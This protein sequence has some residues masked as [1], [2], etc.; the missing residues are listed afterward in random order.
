MVSRW[1]RVMKIEW[2]N[3]GV[4]PGCCQ[5]GGEREFIVHIRRRCHDW[6]RIMVFALCG[7][8]VAPAI[9]W[10]AQIIE[11][12]DFSTP[13]VLISKEGVTTFIF[14][15]SITKVIKSIP[16]M[17]TNTEGAYLFVS[18]GSQDGELIVI[19]T[20]GVLYT[21][22]TVRRSGGGETVVVKDVRVPVSVPQEIPLVKNAPDYVH[23]VV[24][25]LE[26][27]ARGTLPSEYQ[28][29]R[30]DEG[31]LP[32]WIRMPSEGKVYRG[33]QFS[34]WVFTLLNDTDELQTLR[35]QEFFGGRELGVAISA[36]RVEPNKYVRVV[37]VRQ[38]AFK[39]GGEAP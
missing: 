9:G 8:F 17:D 20:S 31:G 22:Q 6:L 39:S 1:W 18:A 25:L 23:R 30:V 32:D 26:L 35:P 29:Q 33:P 16:D 2:G 37:F 3:Y 11:V 10:S 21:F 4:S 14:P 12:Q 7:M 5:E 34:V 38:E 28:V 36:D 13:T 27:G 19:G 15:E 24:A